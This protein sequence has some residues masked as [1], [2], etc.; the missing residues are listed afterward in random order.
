MRHNN[1]RTPEQVAELKA[2]IIRLHKE[3]DYGVTA[4]SLRTKTDKGLIAKWLKKAGVYKTGHRTAAR[5]N[6]NYPAKKLQTASDKPKG[7]ASLDAKR[8]LLS[9]FLRERL[10][11]KNS[12]NFWSKIWRGKYYH[13]P[14]SEQPLCRKVK[15]VAR[16]R[17]KQAFKM[18]GLKRPSGVI[19]KAVG[20]TTTQLA[21]HLASMFRDGMTVDNH[22]T[23]WEIDHIRPLCS[24]DLTDEKQLQEACH[25]SNLQPLLIKE[26]RKKWGKHEAN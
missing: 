8:L 3:L 12:E 15:N 1:F 22:G 11:V 20:C 21:N 13:T 18:R 14:R 10:Q 9:A 16:N 4:I 7:E 17:I 26:N 6:R 2:E 5:I 19:S 23:V 24:F 25:Y